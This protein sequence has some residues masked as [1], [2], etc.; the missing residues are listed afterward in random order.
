MHDLVVRSYSNKE[1]ISLRHASNSGIYFC[2]AKHEIRDEFR[3]ENTT[4]KSES[5]TD[6]DFDSECICLCPICL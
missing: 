3:D 1:R 5:D 6:F 4:D 2:Q